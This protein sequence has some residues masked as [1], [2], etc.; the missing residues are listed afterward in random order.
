MIVLLI[1]LS[2]PF[3]SGKQTPAF[4]IER[5]LQYIDEHLEE[6]IHVTGLA[7]LANTSL[8]TYN[9]YFIQTTGMPPG[10]YILNRKIEKTRGLLTSTDLSVT[11]IA[12]KYGFSSSQYFATV[13]KRFCNMTPSQYRRLSIRTSSHYDGSDKLS[14]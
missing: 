3:T 10:E 4:H 7:G 6:N 14:S 13:F 8:S 5:S 11:E 2:T 1:A 12:C 9:K